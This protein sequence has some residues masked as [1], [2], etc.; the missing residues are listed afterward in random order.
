[1]RAGGTPIKIA[2]FGKIPTR[3]DFIKAT[4]S[5]ALITFLDDWLAQAMA[6]LA[7]DA[8]WKSVYDGLQPLH[9]VLMGPR[10]R[11]A[12]AGHLR[13]SGDQSQ[14]RFPFISV[15]AFD[16]DEP[17]V[18]V[19]YSAL[20]LSRLW[21]RLESLSE[22]VLGAAD[23]GRALLALASTTLELDIGAVGYRA[24]FEDFL[25]QQTVGSLHAL[26]GQS[27]FNGSLRQLLLAL[28]LLLRQVMVSCSSRLDKNLILPLPREPLYRSLVACF[29]MHLIAP[30]LLRSDFELV[31]FLS[32]LGERPCMTLGFSGSSAH[33][34]HSVMHPQAGAARD[35][36]FDAADWAE[37]QVA[38]DSL[39]QNLASY[40]DHPDLSLKSAIHAFHDA[41]IGA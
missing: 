13:A 12:V 15:S 19:R 35:I 2:Y 22:D 38:S 10:S 21:S 25:D 32:R 28:G 39:I 27:G 18:F 14:R 24:T 3:G 40:L 34:L 1:M 31:L 30:F 17:V 9:F 11:R 4:D 29:W 6:L 37:E 33:S 41:F 16:V 26:L 20:V 7:H 5:A 8:R 36:D 23:P